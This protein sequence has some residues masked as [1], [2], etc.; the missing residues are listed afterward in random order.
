[1]SCGATIRNG[2]SVAGSGPP[3]LRNVAVRAPYMHDG[4]ISTL[5]GVLDRYAAGGRTIASEPNA[6]VGSKNPNRSDFVEGF[7]L[8][9]QRR[10]DLLA[11]LLSLTDTQF[12]RIPQWQI[13]VNNAS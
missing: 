3:S 7:T 6:G 5:N 11:L 9:P 2:C 4:S 13:P 1:L 10:Q 12:Y 8:T